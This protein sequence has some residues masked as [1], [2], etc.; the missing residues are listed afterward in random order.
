MRNRSFVY[1]AGVL[2]IA[3]AL[4]LGL[5][6]PWQPRLGPVE[7]QEPDRPADT[8]AVAIVKQSGGPCQVTI[9]GGDGNMSNSS[10]ASL[11][12]GKARSMTIRFPA[13]YT[14]EA[15]TVTRDGSSRRLPLKLTFAGGQRYELLINTDNTVAVVPAPR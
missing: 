6:R 7:T 2:A 14:I 4:V 10:S 8:A 12:S 1:L 3:A 13:P 9:L 5:W 11:A 15:V